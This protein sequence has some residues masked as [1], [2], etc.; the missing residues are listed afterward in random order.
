R[1]TSGGDGGVARGKAP[2]SLRERGHDTHPSFSLSGTACPE[3]SEGERGTGEGLPGRL[4]SLGNVS[5]NV[6]PRP[7]DRSTAIVPPCAS[8]TRLQMPR[9][10]PYPPLRFERDRSTR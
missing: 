7:A 4:G 2:L 9:P 10:R 8:M 5:T 3:R 6:A 1:S